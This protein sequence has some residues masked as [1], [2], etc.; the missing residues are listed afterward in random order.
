MDPTKLKE[1]IERKC[2]FTQSSNFPI[3]K[4][5][6]RPVKAVIPVHLYGQPADMYPIL[7]IAKQ[8]SLLVIEDAC[9]AHGAEYFFEKENRWGR[10]GSMGL[11]AAFSFYP[12]KNLGACGE[13]GAVTTNSER[14]AQQVRML[15]DHGQAKKYVHEMEGYN[16]R[17]DAIQAG[18]LRVK[19]NYLPIWNEKRRQKA[20][21]YNDIIDQF[22]GVTMP[23]ES[24][25]TRS[26]Y[27]LYIIRTQK[28]DELQEFLSENGIATGLH[29]PIP[30]HLQKAYSHLGY[31]RGDFPISECA[32]AEVLSLPMSPEIRT[33]QQEQVVE[34]IKEFFAKG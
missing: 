21:Y 30:L 12:G 33:E 18:F 19:L 26:V 8:Y 20:L 5:T 32:A 31:K 27:H 10:V 28:R 13:A 11:A 7:E 2:F 9:Q 23:H 16:G 17:L 15:R 6:N 1:F 34:A 22:N 14:I 24:Q 4:L 25:K 29:Y 3:N